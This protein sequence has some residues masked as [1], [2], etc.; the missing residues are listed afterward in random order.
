M[1]WT[2][3]EVG[4]PVKGAVVGEIGA[5]LGATAPGTGGHCGGF[6]PPEVGVAITAGLAGSEFFWELLQPKPTKHRAR[7][8]STMLCLNTPTKIP[9]MTNWDFDFP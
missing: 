4:V 5:G 2:T 7:L 1:P 6:G 3:W 9:W 8:K